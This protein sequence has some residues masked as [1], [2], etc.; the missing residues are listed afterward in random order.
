MRPYSSANED[1][2]NSERGRQLKR[3]GIDAETDTD[4]T[5]YKLSHSPSP[6]SLSY[7]APPIPPRP[8]HRSPPPLPHRS[9]P[10]TGFPLG[11]SPGIAELVAS[12][13]RAANLAA[14]ASRGGS[15]SPNPIEEE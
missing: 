10:P 8:R 1:P 6:D 9:P 2:D 3:A 5:N 15:M 13:A 11:L 4:D 12:V 14:A 7:S